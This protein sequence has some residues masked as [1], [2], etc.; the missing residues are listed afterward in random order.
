[1]VGTAARNSRG[2]LVWAELCTINGRL[3]YGFHNRNSGDRRV[4]SFGPRIYKRRGLR[5]APFQLWPA[6]QQHQRGRTRS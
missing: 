6:P 5:L 3:G 2:R 4:I 1:M